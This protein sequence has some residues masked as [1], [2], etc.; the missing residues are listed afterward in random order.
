MLIIV[1]FLAVIGYL[2]Y[3]HRD[4]QEFLKLREPLRQ[5]PYLPMVIL[6]GFFL[7]V[8]VNRVIIRLVGITPWYQDIL[9][10]FALLATLGLSAEVVIQLIINPSVEPEQR[11][12][13]Y[14][15]L[16]SLLAAIISFY[17]GARS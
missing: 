16:A 15:W 13:L 1:G 10:W 14:P 8:F 6:G 11:L 3:V 12:Y 7:G 9:A 17:F 4:F 2:Y 5:E